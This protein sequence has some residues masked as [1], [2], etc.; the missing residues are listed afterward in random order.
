MNRFEKLWEGSVKVRIDGRGMERFFNIAAQRGIVIEKIETK[1]IP[2]AEYDGNRH[3]R[4]DNQKEDKKQGKTVCF[5]ISP[6]NFKRL[7]P[8]ARKTDVRLRITE[9]HGFPFWLILGRRRS[10]WAGGLAAFFLLIYLSSFYV[11]DISFD[12]NHRFTDEMLLHF[13]DTIPVQC[14]M[15]KKEI[16]CGDLEKQ[17]RNAFPEIGWVSAE[18]TGTRLTVHVREN[19]GILKAETG[20]DAPCELTAGSDGTVTK[21]IVR[22]GIV[23]V[24]AGDEVKTG[25]ILV[26]GKLPI[27]DDSETLVKTNLVHADAEVYAETTRTVTWKIPV[28]EEIRAGTGKKRMGV[29]FKFLD[30]EFCFLM[31][32]LKKESSWE[33]FMEESQLRFSKNFYLPVYGGIL[34]AREYIPYEKVLTKS[35]VSDSADRYLNEYMQ[36]LTEKGIQILGSDVKIERSESHWTIHGTLTVV[37]DIAKESPIPEDQEEIQTVDEHH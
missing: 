15:R 3:D 28:V 1:E 30:T 31:P 8:I 33:L 22:N 14:G 20:S 17:I 29:F 7:K 21:I 2:A 13:M 34:A 37:E 25:D 26:S 35:E 23:R 4:Y 19:D 5:E 11:W 32:D 9:K 12:G 10:L 24:K 6:R 18:L 27:Y 36:N 16:S